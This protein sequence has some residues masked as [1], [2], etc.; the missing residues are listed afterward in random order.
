MIY[1]VHI[2]V[3]KPSTHI[4]D[5]ISNNNKLITMESKRIGEKK[6]IEEEI[7][8]KVK[9]DVIYTIRCIN[10]GKQDQIIQKKPEGMRFYDIMT[11]N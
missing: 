5:A 11:F 6:R 8:K 2:T 10:T 9:D 7:S 3:T 4:M 1:I